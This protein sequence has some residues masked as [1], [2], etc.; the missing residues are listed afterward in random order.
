MSKIIYCGTEGQ[1]EA[2]VD[3]VD[4]EYLSKWKWNFKVS[5]GGNVYARRSGL[6]GSRTD[7]SRRII[8]ILMHNEVLKRKGET[9]RNKAYTGDHG[10]RDTLDNRR[11]NLSYRTR[12]EQLKNRRK[13]RTIRQQRAELHIC[14]ENSDLP[15]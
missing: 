10:N 12:L 1:Y 13:Y 9:P 6:I 11:S 2:I 7:G 4:Y 8:T 15:F 3:D 5:R 14:V